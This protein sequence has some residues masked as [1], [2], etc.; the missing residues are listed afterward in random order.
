MDIKEKKDIKDKIASL[1]K[2][3][4]KDVKILCY[5][6]RDKYWRMTP[7][8]VLHNDKGLFLREMTGFEDTLRPYLEDGYEIKHISSNPDVDYFIIF[9]EKQLRN[10]VIKVRRVPRYK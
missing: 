5:W 3:K 6:C 8:S 1:G 4:Q 9:M 10:P 2:A 7:Y